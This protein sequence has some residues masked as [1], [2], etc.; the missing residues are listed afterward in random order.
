MGGGNSTHLCPCKHRCDIFT[1]GNYPLIINSGG[2]VAQL[3][4][5]GAALFD[6]FL[7]SQPTNVQQSFQN[8]L[9]QFSNTLTDAGA[10]FFHQVSQVSDA[11]ANSQAV[12][13]AKAAVRKVGTAWQENEIRLLM[14]IG[15]LQH[16]PPVQIRYIMAD[17]V[18]REA[19]QEQRIE[20]YGDKYQDLFPND[21]G[22]KHYDYRRVMNGVTQFDKNGNDYA[23]TYEEDLLEGDTELTFT[24]QSS[25]ISSIDQ[26]IAYLN[27]GKEDPTSIW[28]APLY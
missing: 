12:R 10:Q 4:Q 14:N 27:Y 26:A 13:Y 21:I 9:H 5:G 17:P 23:T 18:I 8:Q 24:Q 25:V 28:N 3:L 20:G 2:T 11:I 22:E 6:E 7:L 15:E 19:Y 1:K 16:A